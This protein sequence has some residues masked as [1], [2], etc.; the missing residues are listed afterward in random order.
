MIPCREIFSVQRIKF[1]SLIVFYG[2]YL[3]RC[4]IDKQ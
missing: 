2:G 1:E 4:G 3:R